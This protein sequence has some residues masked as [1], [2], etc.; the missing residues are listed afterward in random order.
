MVAWG[1]PDLAEK[2]RLP[3][4]VVACGAVVVLAACACATRHQTGYWRDSYT[5]FSHAVS[6]TRENYLAQNELGVALARQGRYDE[7]FRHFQESLRISPRYANPYY[8]WGVA[9]MELGRPGEAI[10]LLGETVRLKPGFTEAYNNLGV[11]LFDTG[12]LD[13]AIQNFTEALSIDPDNEKARENL[14]NCLQAKGAG[15]SAR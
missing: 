8:N 15:F 5:L 2:L 6:V 14:A 13:E 3:G 9:L 1:V 12:R 11:A 7:A 4:R 10:G